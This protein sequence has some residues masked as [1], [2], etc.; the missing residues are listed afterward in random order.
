MTSLSA[1]RML[2]NPMHQCL[3]ICDSAGLSASTN[4]TNCSPRSGQ[5]A[6]KQLVLQKTTSSSW[7]PWCFVISVFNYGIILLLK[8]PISVICYLLK[9]CYKTLYQE[10]RLYKYGVTR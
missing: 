1:E 7:L 6:N 4:N 2:G 5:V 9:V 3:L 8:R 10:L